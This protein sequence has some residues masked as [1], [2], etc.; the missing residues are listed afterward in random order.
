LLA[1]MVKSPYLGNQ[2]Y[3]AEPDPLL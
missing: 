3:L 1:A 2:I